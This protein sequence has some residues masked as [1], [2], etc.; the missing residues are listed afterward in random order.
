MPPYFLYILALMLYVAVACIVFVITI[1]LACFQSKRAL[2]K[3]I[4]AGMASSFPGVFFFQIVSAPF[5]IL[6]SLTAIAV[7]HFFRPPD[8]IILFLAMGMICIPVIASLLGFYVGW[9]AGWEWAAGRS[10]RRFLRSASVVGTIIHFLCNRF[11]T[12][13]RLF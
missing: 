8:L 3:K 6:L 1:F 7:S 5:V 11:P 12:L 2:A 4:A 10:V 13:E 9:R